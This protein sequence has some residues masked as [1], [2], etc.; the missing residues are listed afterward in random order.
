MTDGAGRASRRQSVTMQR[1]SRRESGQ[2]AV[3][4]AIVMPLFVFIIFGMI[5]LGLLHQARLMTKYAAY[6]AVRAGSLS[7]AKP[8]VMKNAATAVLLP[9][10][11]KTSPLR[12]GDDRFQ[13]QYQVYKVRSASDYQTGI[14]QVTSNLKGP[15]DREMVEIT[16]CAPTGNGGKGKDFDDYRNAGDDGNAWKQFDDLKLAIQVTLYMPLY[17]PYVNGL[18]WWAARGEDSDGARAETMRNLRLKSSRSD[19]T[20][21]KAANGVWTLKELEGQAKRGNYIMPV[22]AAYTMRMMSNYDD[23]VTFDSKNNCHVNWKKK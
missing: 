21:R 19:N 18:I 22:R 5:Q 9:L 23:S 7:R 6:K 1:R 3:E 13:P 20:D 12:S 2:S 15:Y 14:Q 10:L 4:T 11:A 17:I 8:D 16:I